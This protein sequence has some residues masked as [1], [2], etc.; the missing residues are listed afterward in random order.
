MSQEQIFLLYLFAINVFAL[1]AMG[2]DKW[3]AI[4]QGWRVPEKT[5]LLIGL[6]G[7][8]LGLLLGSKIYRHKT[9]KRIFRIGIPL[10][11]MINLIEIYFLF[12]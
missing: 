3:K 5:L 1:L 7:G 6:L 10:L 4:R 2:W 9:Q 11:L 8:A 12:S